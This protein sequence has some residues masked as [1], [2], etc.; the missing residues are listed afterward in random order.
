MVHLDL[1]YSDDSHHG[2]SA[3]SYTH[4]NAIWSLC[5]VELSN[6]S[7]LITLLHE[8]NNEHYFKSIHRYCQVSAMLW[9]LWTS[10][11]TLLHWVC[12]YF[13]QWRSGDTYESAKEL[14][15]SWER[16]GKNMHPCSKSI[17]Y[18]VA[19]GLAYKSYCSLAAA[20]KIVSGKEFTHSALSLSPPISQQGAK[21]Y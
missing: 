11:Y 6:S 15:N 3:T 4:W 13:I 1:V 12:I 7:N 14:Q 21:H 17:T 16:K 2:I 9:F 19:L 10:V 5:L 20:S 8:W 18:T